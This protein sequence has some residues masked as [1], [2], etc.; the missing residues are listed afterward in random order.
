MNNTDIITIAIPTIISIGSFTI[1]F[2]TFRNSV[3]SDSVEIMKT[4]IQ[5]QAKQI[6][7]LQNQ[8]QD[9]EK[10]YVNMASLVKDALVEYFGDHSDVAK[11]LLTKV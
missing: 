11:A 6:K 1:A 5:Q 2:F 9:M 7:D 4:A 10:K 3:T 8:M